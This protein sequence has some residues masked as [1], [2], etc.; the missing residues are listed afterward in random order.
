MK[1]MAETYECSKCGRYYNERIICPY[2]L[3]I[4][5]ELVGHIFV[6]N[7]MAKEYIEWAKDKAFC[8]SGRHI[9]DRLANLFEENIKQE[10]IN[11]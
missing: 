7:D 5:T 6:S 1:K 4:F 8:N 2:C 9:C 10:K 11:E 3:D